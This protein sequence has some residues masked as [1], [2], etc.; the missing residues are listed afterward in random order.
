MGYPVSDEANELLAQWP[1]RARALFDELL[2]DAGSDLQR[3]L[4]QRAVVA[5]HTPAEVHAFADE[6]RALP[7]EKAFQACTLDDSVPNDFTVM[8]LLTAESDP[9]FAFELKGGHLDPAED[10][11]EQPSPRPPGVTPAAAGPGAKKSAPATF[12]S[13]QNLPNASPARDWGARPSAPPKK[14][15]APAGGAANRLLEDL[16]NEATRAFSVS[17]REHELDVDGGL[18]LDDALPHA[19]KAVNAGTPVPCAIGPKPGDSRRLILLLQVSTTGKTRAWQLYDPLSSELL[20]ANEGDLL[21][22]TELP[23]ANKAMRRLTRMVLPAARS[24]GFVP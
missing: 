8:Q 19:L 20:W 16:V 15:P 1:A 2:D 6:I 9:L 21:Q 3:E 22:R 4:I 24:A 12:D 5:A 17:W 7:D 23:F 14:E 11:D 10:D 18:S 13:H